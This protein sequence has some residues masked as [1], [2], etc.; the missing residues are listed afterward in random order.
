V[1]ATVTAT[2]AADVDGF[3][4]LSDVCRCC[5]S[6]AGAASTGTPTRASCRRRPD[7]TGPDGYLP[8]HAADVS[9][10]VAVRARRTRGAETPVRFA[11][12]RRYGCLKVIRTTTVTHVSGSGHGSHHVGRSDRREQPFCDLM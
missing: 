4:C 11:F 10:T 9:G 7:H 12:L 8:P 6:V 5:V 3:D 1:T 2:V